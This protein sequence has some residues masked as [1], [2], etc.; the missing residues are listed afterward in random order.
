MAVMTGKNKSPQNARE[1]E[2]IHKKK[3]VLPLV[4][5]LVVLVLLIGSVV[6]IVV[7][8]A[9]NIREN[10]L[11]GVLEN[12]PVLNTLLDE[13]SPTADAPLTMADLQNEIAIYRSLLDAAQND[14]ASSNSQVSSLML[15]NNSLNERAE[16]L[17]IEVAALLPLRD[18]FLP[19]LVS[20]NPEIFI[21]I[22]EMIHPEEAA[23]I[24][25]SLMEDSIADA[26]VTEY[27]AMFQGMSARNAAALLS[28]MM[29]DNQVA[30][31]VNIIENL[32]LDSQISIMSALD[33]ED[34]SLLATLMAPQFN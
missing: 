29:E 20:D 31:V 25:T 8:N 22:F 5:S 14:L 26:V 1:F 13:A 27:V 23:L 24:F 16:A 9:F 12:V 11:R 2:D 10:F 3:S 17:E 33:T 32:P 19:S 21:Q 28:A 18:E 6:A 4:L 7:F 34:S 15:E 30:L